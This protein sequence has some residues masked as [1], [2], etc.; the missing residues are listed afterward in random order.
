MP[1]G[2]Q[3]PARA[4]VY[5]FVR[6]D[7]RRLDIDLLA[8]I[9]RALGVSEAETHHWIA[10]CRIAQ[11]RADAATLVKVVDWVPDGVHPFVGRTADLARL[12]DPAAPRVS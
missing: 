6:T 8:D 7:R 4:T 2:E 11:Y 9:V 10:A 5:D 3:C 12:T 1:A